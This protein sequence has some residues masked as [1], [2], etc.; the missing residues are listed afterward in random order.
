MKRSVL[1]LFSGEN[2]VLS[3]ILRLALTEKG[4]AYDVEHVGDELQSPVRLP[5]RRRS[6]HEFHRATIIDRDLKIEDVHI[7]LEYLDDKYP[8]P[9]LFPTGPEKKAK[10]RL[11]IKLIDQRVLPYLDG[12]NSDNPEELYRCV[13]ECTLFIR[14]IQGIFNENTNL[15]FDEEFSVLDCYFAPL[16]YKLFR[17]HQDT[18]MSNLPTKI[19]N[20]Y[21]R[22]HSREQ[23]IKSLQLAPS[24]GFMYEKGK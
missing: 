17:A 7:A 13:D 8:H 9:P 23:F 11:I 4:I 15:L 10:V 22:I 21:R 16:L 3:H 18:R 6:E 19:A 24:R 20:Y 12:L 14:D 2:D 1:T 5:S